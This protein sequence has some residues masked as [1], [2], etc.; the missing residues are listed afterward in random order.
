MIH[1]NLNNNEMDKEKE[2]L[3]KKFEENLKL[4]ERLDDRKRRKIDENQKYINPE[5]NCEKKMKY[6]ERHQIN[7]KERINENIFYPPLWN[8]RLHYISQL[9]DQFNLKRVRD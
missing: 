8:Q 2:E 1:T 9:I 3:L 5:Q 7:A 4:K 6:F